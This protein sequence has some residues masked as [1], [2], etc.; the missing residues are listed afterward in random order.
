MIGAGP[1]GLTAARDLVLRGYGVTVFE[2][3]PEAGGMLR[4]GI[5]EYRLPRDVLAKEIQA[6]VD[7]GIE[8][9]CHTRV[10]RDISWDTL[11]NQYAA[12]YV[13][14]GAQKSVPA[15]FEG[16]N[17][18]G[19]TGAV[20]FLRELHLGGKPYVGTRVAV[21]GG[22]NSAI[23]AAQCA[24]R[25][26]AETVDLVYRRT[27]ADMPALVEEVEA[28]EK[29][30]VRMRFLLSPLRFEAEHNRVIGM[31]CQQMTLGEFDASGRRKPAPILGTTTTLAVD[32]VIL[33]I[34]QILDDAFD[35]P[36]A[37]LPLTAGGW[38]ETVA[39]SR[40]RTA[41]PM[42]FA[43]GDVVTGPHT[44]VGAI[45]AGHR[46]AAEIDDAIR[47]SRGEPPW[48][49]PD[50]LTIEV[51]RQIDAEIPS[52]PRTALPEAEA[53]E[54]VR[55]FREVVLGLSPAAALAEAC[56]CL[57]CDLEPN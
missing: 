47:S 9:R 18:K 44:V 56:R 29:E 20:E 24:L 28:A 46:A 45:A 25:L 17:L 7:L 11:R 37:G 41:L 38:I 8:L 43:G 15:D 1:A 4:W 48:K 53:V 39:G 31:V 23:D 32:H 14:I 22:G 2:E 34:G 6:I 40:S 33:A 10:G 54:R 30:G 5:P 51:P 52:T 3:L 27:R 13:A 26:G 55:D 49:E 42:V 50:P 19:V 12:V 35:L 36:G 16:K 57:S 21:I